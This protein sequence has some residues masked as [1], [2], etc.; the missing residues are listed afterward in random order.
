MKSVNG[1]K[2]MKKE[3]TRLPQTKT[4]ILEM[5]KKARYNQYAPY[6]TPLAF[7]SSYHASLNSVNPLL[8]SNNLQ[9][10]YNNGATAVLEAHK[11]IYKDLIE[12]DWAVK[13]F[14]ST[15]EY[16]GREPG[17]PLPNV[18]PP[19]PINV[20]LQ[21]VAAVV[22]E[23]RVRAGAAKAQQ[24]RKGKKEKRMDS[25]E[26]SSAHEES[27]EDEIDLTA[28][29]QS[30]ST[31]LANHS[32]RVAAAA[33]MASSDPD[34]FKNK[35]DALDKPGKDR[36]EALQ[37]AWYERNGPDEPIPSTI[38]QGLVDQA[39]HEEAMMKRP[40]RQA[41]LIAEAAI[42]NIQDDVDERAYMRALH[43]SMHV[44]E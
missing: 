28:G 43:Q 35:F 40:A 14:S 11:T 36:F 31:I 4:W 27:S 25:S 19:L 33:R 38:Y 20:P 29:D 16:M 10:I 1:R 44:H 9:R 41:K 13:T 12:N 34:K 8:A 30:S 5:I 2:D 6:S 3:T 7:E 22:G 21:A 39:I 18:L 23:K 42:S 15:F 26:D 32:G 24:A 17:V 37:A